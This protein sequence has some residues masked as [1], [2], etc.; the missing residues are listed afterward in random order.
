MNGQTPMLGSPSPNPD[1]ALKIA[2]LVEERGWNQEEFARN[3]SLNRQTVRQILLPNGKRRLR[4]A[5][6][7]ACARALGVAVSELREQPLERL[8]PRMHVRPLEEGEAGLRRLY[9]TATQPQLLAW[10]ERNPE[11]AR[12]LTGEEIDE[13][14]S[15]QGT[16]GPLTAVGVEHYVGL[17]ER[18]RK[19][20]QQVHAVAGTE[21]LDVLERLVGLMY[22]KIQPYSDR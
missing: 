4:N 7:S 1:L 17:I 3:A 15:L 22:E 5:T 16:G 11:R 20:I 13:L 8:L 18:K 21:Y 10:L 14:L 12:Q 9:E 19:L 2:R 6:V